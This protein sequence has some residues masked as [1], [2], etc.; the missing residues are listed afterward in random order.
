M[1]VDIFHTIR[2][3]DALNLDQSVEYFFQEL[4]MIGFSRDS[5]FTPPL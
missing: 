3:F 2:N 5:L 1:N 4:N